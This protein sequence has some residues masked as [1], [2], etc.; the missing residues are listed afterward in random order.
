MIVPQTILVESKSGDVTDCF[1]I[2]S[3]WNFE[4][5]PLGRQ[6]TK[7]TFAATWI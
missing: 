3:E 4:T 1:K 6:K 2:A 7:N 5:T